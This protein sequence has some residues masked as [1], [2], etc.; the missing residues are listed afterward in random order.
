M[1][2]SPPVFPL[3]TNHLQEFKLQDIELLYKCVSLLT[4]LS[5]SPSTHRYLQMLFNN[6]KRF[7]DVCQIVWWF[8]ILSL[9]SC[10]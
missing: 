9:Q 4:L 5:F 8:A 2:T 6:Y 1:F 3:P 7:Q 10:G